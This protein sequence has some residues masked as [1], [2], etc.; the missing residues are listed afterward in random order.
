MVVELHIMNNNTFFLLIFNNLVYYFI[1]RIY[2][3]VLYSNTYYVIYY[4]TKPN[5][6][7]WV[8]YRS[9]IYILKPT[10]LTVPLISRIYFFI[11]MDKFRFT[12]SIFLSTK[13][14]HLLDKY[15]Q[16]KPWHSLGPLKR[17]HA[18]VYNTCIIGCD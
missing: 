8:R 12:D 3:W 9:D 6:S 1:C 15:T 5:I 14:E 11:Y 2:I 13:K 18:R 10:W 4:R 17:I 7:E 16:K